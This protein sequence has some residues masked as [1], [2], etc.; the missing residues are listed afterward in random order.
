MKVFLKDISHVDIDL[1]DKYPI[2]G[3]VFAIT[4]QNCESIRE[5]VEKLPFY[6]PVIGEIAPLPKYAIEELIFFCRLSGI[7]ITE[8]NSREKLSCPLITYTGDSDWNALVKSQDGY[9]TDKI[10]LNEIKKK[11]PQA[12]VLTKD[13]L[14]ELWPEIYNFWGKWDWRTD[15]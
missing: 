9:K 11:S 15:D 14:L 2:H 12:L 5:K 10:M 7:I 6:I 13:E 4:A 8:K 3:V 1:I